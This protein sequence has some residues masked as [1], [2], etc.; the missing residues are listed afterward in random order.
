VRLC[1]ASWELSGYVRTGHSFPYLHKRRLVLSWLRDALLLA[2]KDSA[3]KSGL[4][5]LP[6]ASAVQFEKPAFVC[7]R[8][9]HQL[10]VLQAGSLYQVKSVGGLKNKHQGAMG[11]NGNKV[12]E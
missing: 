1:V 10:C 6:A 5:V 11:I 8:Q 12:S 2:V 3:C 9:G 4:W 7:R